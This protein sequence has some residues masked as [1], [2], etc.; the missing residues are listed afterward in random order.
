[1]KLVVLGMALFSSFSFACTCVQGTLK[2]TVDSSDY[3]Y[4]GKV[5]SSNLID[6]HVVRSELIVSKELK[7]YPDIKFLTSFVNL[8]SCDMDVT[9]GHEYIVF[10]NY[11]KTPSIGSCSRTQPVSYSVEEQEKL[12]KKVKDIAN[13][14]INKDIKS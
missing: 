5:I 9:V 12:I 10:G 7:A 14:S 8:T 6:D 2:E 13:K 4:I 11:G 1:M 3:A